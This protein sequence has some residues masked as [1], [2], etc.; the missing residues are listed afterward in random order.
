MNR[1]RLR[2]ACLAVMTGLLG[3]APQSPAAELV[4]H[5]GAQGVWLRSPAIEVFV[6]T[7]P[8]FRLLSIRRPGQESII[9]G[10][11]EAESGV[12][13]GYMRSQQ[14]A[15]SFDVGNQPADVLEQTATAIKVRLAPA[16][17]L[18]YTASLRLD[19]HEPV[20]ELETALGNVSDKPDTVGCWSIVAFARGEGTM[21]VPFAAERR[22][23][24]RLVI[25][26]WTPWPQPTI[27][28]GRDALAIDTAGALEGAFKLGVITN[29]GWVSMRRGNEVIFFHAPFDPAAN[30][31]EDGANITVFHHQ[32]SDNPRVWCEIEQVAPQ[33]TLESQQSTPPFKQTIRLIP[34][35]PNTP[36]PTTQPG[37]NDVDTLRLALEDA[38]PAAATQPSR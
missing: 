12:R 2:V 23:R 4:E 33:Y 1:R 30:Y 35:D 18:Q 26:W 28:F 21:L 37:Q 20:I 16:A 25:P 31:P 24:R 8:K 27:R 19:E 15:T 17:G 29:A 11:K 32:R 9:A 22:A 10:T 5:D 14:V 36:M 38:V 34:L 3:A 7:Q 13:L 6:A